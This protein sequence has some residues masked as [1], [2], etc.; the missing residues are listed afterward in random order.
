MRNKFKSCERQNYLLLEYTDIKFSLC[1]TDNIFKCIPEKKMSF[2]LLSTLKEKCVIYWM[3][4][5]NNKRDT[6]Q[7]IKHSF[8]LIETF[9]YT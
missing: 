7:M 8:K 2:S 9:C 4:R 1:E 5:L 3:C 6:V